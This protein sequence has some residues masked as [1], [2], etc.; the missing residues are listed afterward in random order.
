LY[1]VQA[2]ERVTSY[3]NGFTKDSQVIRWFWELVSHN[4]LV[5]M[6]TKLLASGLMNAE[7]CLS[8]NLHFPHFLMQF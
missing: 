2:L 7:A 5:F 6:I 3:Q 4:T 1:V 8:L